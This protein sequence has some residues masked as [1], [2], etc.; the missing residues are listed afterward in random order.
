M[1]RSQLS[2]MRET[3][4]QTQT[5]SKANRLNAVA[6][7]ETREFPGH[8]QSRR[9]TCGGVNPL[10]DRALEGPRLHP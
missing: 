2:L 5:V 10:R 4:T 1:L 9:R 3:P 8:R 6:D 7:R